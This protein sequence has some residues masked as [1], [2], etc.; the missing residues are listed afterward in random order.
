MVSPF[1]GGEYTT[2]ALKEVMYSNQSC[3][4]LEVK[5]CVIFTIPIREYCT[6]YYPK[7]KWLFIPEPDV[8]VLNEGK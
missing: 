1:I 4:V 6:T 8:T 5:N 2:P 3:K 7:S